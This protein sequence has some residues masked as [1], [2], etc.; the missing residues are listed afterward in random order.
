MNKEIV[1]AVLER[2]GG[3]CE[4]CGAADYMVQ[5]HHVV[6][7]NGKRKQHENEFSL[8]LLCWNCHHSTWGVHGREGKELDIML[9]RKLQETYFSQGYLED[10]VRI[11]MGGK[12]Y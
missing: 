4:N 2:S 12:L 10:E 11:K 3:C 5:I 1:Q 9:K 6:G 8:I 7:G